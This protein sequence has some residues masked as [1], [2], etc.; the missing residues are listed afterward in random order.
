MRTM[1]KT[2][3]GLGLFDLNVDNLGDRFHFISC[4]WDLP[5]AT[6]QTLRH[7][8]ETFRISVGLGGNIFER[9]FDHLGDLAEP[10]WFTH[11]WRLC[12]RFLSPIM[13][14]TEFEVPLM[15]ERDTTLIDAFLDTGIWQIGDL[16]DLNTVRR[17]KCVYSK[18]DLFQPDGQTILPSMMNKLPG[19]SDWTFP[20]EKP[21]KDQF[22]LWCNALQ[23]LTSPEL[24][25]RRS[26]GNYINPPHKSTGWYLSNSK[27]YLYKKCDN[28]TFETHRIAL[29]SRGSRRPKY[30][31]CISSSIPPLDPNN[32]KYAAVE[33]NSRARTFSVL[34]SSQAFRPPTPQRRPIPD[35]LRSW[36]NPGL[37]NELKCDDDKW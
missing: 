18:S 33:V 4:H 8:Y 12:H 16:K 9:D 26:L 1:S 2:F 34:S 32:H 17:Y 21:T 35:I 37:W 20:R 24:R 11:T 31:R 14:A 3:G 13:F 15:R 19:S 30:V 7:A 10:C 22:T 27:K 29:D 23:H 28:D 36:T 5:T 25:L 6:G